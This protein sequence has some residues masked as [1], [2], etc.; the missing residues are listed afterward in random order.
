M[1]IYNL[2]LT[3]Q[4]VFSLAPTWRFENQHEHSWTVF[5]IYDVL[6]MMSF[7]K[8][9]H[10]FLSF[11]IHHRREKRSNYSPRLLSI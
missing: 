1:T 2:F 8:E 9:Q 3:C 4:T 6:K 7:Y 5:L 10:R 11:L